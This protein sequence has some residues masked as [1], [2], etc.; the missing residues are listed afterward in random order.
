MDTIEIMLVS[1]I[2]ANVYSGMDAEVRIRRG[3]DPNEIERSWFSEKGMKNRIYRLLS[4]GRHTVYS[5][6]GYKLEE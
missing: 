2:A 4:P 1:M 6:R 3:K 5:L